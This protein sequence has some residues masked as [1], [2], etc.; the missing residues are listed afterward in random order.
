MEIDDTPSPFPQELR[1][2]PNRLCVLVSIACFSLMM[3][4]YNYI[5]LIPEGKPSSQQVEHLKISEVKILLNEQNPYNVT[6]TSNLDIIQS[7]V[8]G[9]QVEISVKDL[10]GNSTDTPLR[11]TRSGKRYDVHISYTEEQPDRRFKLSNFDDIKPNINNIFFI[12]SRCGLDSEFQKRSP[13]DGVVF[14]ARQVCSI[15]STAIMNPNRPVYIL[16]TCPLDNNFYEKSPKYVQQLMSYPNIHLVQLKMSEL[17]IRTNV[18]ELYFS[19]K[20]KE[21]KFPVA[22]IS[23][24]MRLLTLWKFGGTYMDIDV[25]SIR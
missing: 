17:F 8:D 1:F 14:N 12:E 18:E 3:C 25:V 24:V 6:V 13:D 10:L 9:A 23:D 20:F 22:H 2:K 4:F 19:G 7:T 11:F 21:S 15:E 16:H 5:K